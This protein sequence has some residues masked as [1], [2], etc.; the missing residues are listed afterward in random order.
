MKTSRPITARSYAPATAGG[1]GTAHRSLLTAHYNGAVRLTS[2]LTLCALLAALCVLP[3]IT[4]TR[5]AD[6]SFIDC[7]ASLGWISDR[8]W[9]H[10]PRSSPSAL[11]ALL[12]AR[13]LRPTAFVVPLTG[14][15]SITALGSPLTENFD[16]LSSTVGTGVAWTDNSTISGA[17]TSQTTYNVATGSSTTGAM[18]SFGV[19]GANPVTDRA[20]GAINSNTTGDI[21]Y[22]F[23]L[24]NNTGANIGALVV[25][26]TGE[27]W[28]DAG[29]NPAVAQTINFGY[30][31]A[32]AGVVTDANVPT[33]GWTG[34]NV[35]NF[36]SPKFTTTAGLLDGNTAANR[37]AVS[38]TIVFPTPVANGQE[39]WIRWQDPNDA[40]SDHGL[41]IDD[42]SITALALAPNTI[43]GQ[44]L[45]PGGLAGIGSGRTVTLLQNGTAAGSGTTDVSGNY[46]ISGV[47]LASGDK[48]AVFIDNA[49]EFGATVTLSGTSDITTL[50]IWQNSLIVRTA[51][52]TITNANLKSAQGGSPDADLTAIYTVDG[53]NNLTTP[54]GVSLQIWSSSS[55]APGANINDGGDWTNNGTFTAGASTVKLNSSAGNQA[56]GGNFDSFF[57]SLT[58]DNVPVNP[59]PSTNNVITLKVN[60]HVTS[61]LNVTHGVFNQGA[62]ASDDFTL[63]TNTVTVGSGAT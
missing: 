7:H 49:A 60:T 57:S 8:A 39:I 54:A 43:S 12:A 23:K 25:S 14:G 37:T 53:S 59:T 35:L 18:Y 47:T 34:V 36:T 10:G 44:V 20:L 27:Q 42:L 6:S 16:G 15:G 61:A 38:S 31:V 63:T 5:A 4:S 3:F 58:I 48:L 29:N 51:S 62:S 30:Q 28:R 52:G 41:A 32:T 21:F 46:S 9:M 1:R 24:T 50:N 40:N 22:G 19:A 26:Y 45:T 13:T 56:I 55:Y 33:T 17:Y 2:L 11:N